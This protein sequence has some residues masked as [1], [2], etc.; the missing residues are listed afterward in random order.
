MRKRVREEG[1]P[2]EVSH[3]V[4]PA[5]RCPPPNKQSLRRPSPPVPVL[6]LGPVRPDAAEAADAGGLPA[7][8]GHRREHLRRPRRRDVVVL[9]FDDGV[10]ADGAGGGVGHR[11]IGLTCSALG[12]FGPW[13]SVNDTR[14]PFRRSSNRAPSRSLRWKKRSFPPPSISMN[15]KPPSFSR[16]MTP[17]AIRSVPS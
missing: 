7:R 11:Q 12:P 8:A 14:W 16:L 1:A 17:S 3:V 9:C 5:H 10:A 13:P 6:A 4:V 2:E 15:P